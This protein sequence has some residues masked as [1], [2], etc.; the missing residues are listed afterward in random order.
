MDEINFKEKN[1]LFWIMDI[2]DILSKKE[3]IYLKFIGFIDG[4]GNI[5]DHDFFDLIKDQHIENNILRLT[6]LIS[7]TDIFF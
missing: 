4:D 7:I 6:R 1:T 2:N 5:N 3:E